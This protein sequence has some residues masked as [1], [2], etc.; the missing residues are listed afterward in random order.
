M[1]VKDYFFSPTI[2]VVAKGIG[3]MDNVCCRFRERGGYTTRDDPG[4]VWKMDNMHILK[5]LATTSIFE[6]PAGDHTDIYLIFLCHL[7]GIAF[8]IA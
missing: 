5:T 3:F 1:E 8:S 4:L 6:M 2:N 7:T